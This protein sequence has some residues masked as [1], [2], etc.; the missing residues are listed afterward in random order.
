M[1][2]I[3]NQLALRLADRSSRKGFLGT[4]GKV[5]L[6]VAVG[7]FAGGGTALADVG[8]CGYCCNMTYSK[9]CWASYNTCSCPPNTLVGNF[10]CCMHQGRQYNYYPCFSSYDPQYLICFG[11]GLGCVGAPVH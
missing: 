6:G 7:V 2:G 10:F 1:Q 3:P 9:T 11:C 4:I 8:P 5:G